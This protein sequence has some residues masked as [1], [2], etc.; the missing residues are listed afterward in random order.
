MVDG[1]AILPGSAFIEVAI[2]AARQMSGSSDVELMNLEIFRP[3]E[4]HATRLTELSTIVSIETGQ[5]E[6]RSREYMSEDDWSVHAVARM[7]KSVKTMAARIEIIGENEPAAEIGTDEAYETARRF[8]LDYSPSFNLLKKVQSSSA[9]RVLSV[10]LHPAAKPAHPYLSYDL[11]PISV[12]AS[13]H[14]LVA[15]FGQL[16]GDMSGAPYIPVRFGAV[17]F[18]A[19]TGDICSAHLHIQRFSTHSLKVRVEL[20]DA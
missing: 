11:N 4:L 10:Q 14:G 17:R 7:R 5:I 13:F 1:K 6:I 20:F 9:K 2:T 8:G 16:T 15:L 3:L 18:R 12:D 19:N